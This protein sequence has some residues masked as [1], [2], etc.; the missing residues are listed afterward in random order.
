MGGEAEEQDEVMLVE[1]NPRSAPR[2]SP[3]TCETAKVEV[4]E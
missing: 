4:E 1:N 2:C 3:M